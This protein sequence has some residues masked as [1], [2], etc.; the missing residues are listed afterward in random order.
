MKT[1]QRLS[2]SYFVSIISLPAR[3]KHTNSTNVDHVQ[4][5]APAFH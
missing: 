3:L 5:G 2:V 1:A 4:I